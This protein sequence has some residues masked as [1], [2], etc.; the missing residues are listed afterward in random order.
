VPDEADIA[1][2]LV[3]RETQ[4]R[5]D[6]AR[7]TTETGAAEC[8]ECGEPVP[9]VRRTLGKSTCIDCATLAERRARLFART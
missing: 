9:E 4:S 5:I 1:N 6:A 8:E 2:D 7:Q 3:L